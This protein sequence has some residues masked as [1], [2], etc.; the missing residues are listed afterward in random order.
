[1]MLYTS[2]LVF[3]FDW[4]PTNVSSSCVPSV[5]VC[6]TGPS[7]FPPPPHHSAAVLPTVHAAPVGPSSSPLHVCLAC[8]ATLARWITYSYP[9]AFWLARWPK[10]GVWC[11]A[12]G[13]VQ[14]FAGPSPLEHVG[15]LPTPPPSPSSLGSPTTPIPRSLLLLST[16]IPWSLYK[17]WHL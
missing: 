13:P 11:R 14:H 4:S 6:V 9:W 15:S 12:S 16:I 5:S 17:W 7:S 3:N 10:I 8:W 1:M 2:P